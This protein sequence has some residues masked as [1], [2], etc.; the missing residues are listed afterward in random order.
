MNL[1]NVIINEECIICLESIDNKQIN[2]L[3]DIFP[4]NCEHKNSFHT[5]C[6]NKWIEDCNNK[7]IIPSCPLCRNNLNEVNLNIPNEI[8]I[9]SP[10][11]I[12]MNNDNLIINDINKICKT[13]QITCVITISFLIIFSMFV[14]YFN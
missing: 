10:V 12:Q 7:Q 13:C 9:N 8:I 4:K 11:V 2:N 6:I 1:E 5:D 3:D 14:P